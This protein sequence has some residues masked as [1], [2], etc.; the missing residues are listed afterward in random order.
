MSDPIDPDDFDNLPEDVEMEPIPQVFHSFEHDEP[1]SECIECKRSLESTT[2][3]V[4]KS[5]SKGE[6]LFEFAMCMKCLFQMH[7]DFSQLTKER[8]EAFVEMNRQFYED[9]DKCNFC[10]IQKEDC[11]EFGIGG[12][13]YGRQMIKYQEPSLTCGSCS[14]RVQ[15][16]ISPQTRR[17]IDE[18]IGDFLGGPPGIENPLPSDH[19]AFL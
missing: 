14:E 12:V 15:S 5:T 17:R 8:I 7:K 6:V 13:F 19:L 1:F 3:V 11:V 10:G 2:Y 18:F 9:I 16:F 4:R